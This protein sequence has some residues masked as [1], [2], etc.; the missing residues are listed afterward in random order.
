MPV[1]FKMTVNP[2][3]IDRLR[4]AR[5]AARQLNA[6]VQTLAMDAGGLPGLHAMLKAANDLDSV[7]AMV[8]SDWRRAAA[9]GVVR[10]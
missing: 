2:A 3:L 1:D 8:E 5:G 7:L 9:E 4:K 6:D 10:A